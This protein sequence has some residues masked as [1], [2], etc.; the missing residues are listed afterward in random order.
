MNSDEWRQKEKDD[1]D[2]EKF[3]KGVR[4]RDDQVVIEAVAPDLLVDFL[5]LKAEAAAGRGEPSIQATSPLT[6]EQRDLLALIDAVI[7][8]AEQRIDLKGCVYSVD[9]ASADAHEE[10]RQLR[11][12]VE[13]L[14]RR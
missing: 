7:P 6:D 14:G 2:R 1:R 8:A 13:G 5:R 4:K 9:P 12:Y 11:M 3:C 10:M